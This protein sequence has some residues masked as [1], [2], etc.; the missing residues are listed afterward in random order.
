MLYL[1]CLLMVAVPLVF[2]RRRLSR[3]REKVPVRIHV[4]GTRGKSG[5]VRAVA[6]LLAARGMRVLAKTTG[7][8]PE[9]I[10]PDGKVVPITRRGPANIRE[11]AAALGKAAAIGADAL[12][13]EGMALQPETIWFS[14][15]MLRATHAGV[16]NT[17][18]DHGETMGS[19]REGVLNTLR[20]MFP[21]RG[22]LFTCAEEGAEEIRVLAARAGV[23]CTV[24]PAPLAD[25]AMPLA[26][27]VTARI[28]EGDVPLPALTPASAGP[29]RAFA[30]RAGGG[31]SLF[32]YDF[33][34]ANDVFSSRLLLDACVEAEGVPRVALLATR[35]DR[36]A[37][38]REFVSWLAEEKRFEAVALMGSHA[39]Y[40]AF[41]LIRAGRGKDL[42]RVRPWLHPDALCRELLRWAEKRGGRGA[43]VFA[44]GNT[45]GYG[46]R[47]RGA[48][49]ARGDSGGKEGAHAG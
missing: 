26:R 33:L 25:Q 27:A 2:E 45:H 9:Y 49:A 38:T 14:E 31:A 36:P 5:A 40:A 32:L 12:V 7:D 46:E 41:R 10:L 39:G 11:H 22:E 48:V 17:R 6:G 42:L 35:A 29:P 4:H 34:S 24:V 3:W 13:V 15:R 21:L 28:L 23:P 37:R 20:H 1:V 19:G 44:L 47:W 16:T 30:V 8:R 43:A 18:P